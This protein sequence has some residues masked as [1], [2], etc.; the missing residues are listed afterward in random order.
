[1]LRLTDK[2]YVLHAKLDAR[3]EGTSA[4]Q[5]GLTFKLDD[6]IPR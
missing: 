2:G 4:T 3:G 6:V 1:V 5:A